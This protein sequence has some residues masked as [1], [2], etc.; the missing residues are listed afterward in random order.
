LC[1]EG[2]PIHDEY[3]NGSVLTPGRVVHGFGHTDIA[4]KQLSFELFVHNP[5]RPPIGLN[6]PKPVPDFLQAL[7]LLAK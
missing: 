4:T 7:L 3:R 5:D 2:G 6:S 1:S